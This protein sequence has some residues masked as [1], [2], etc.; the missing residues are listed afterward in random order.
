MGHHRFDQIDVD[1]SNLRVS[2]AGE[3]RPLE[4]RAFRLLQFLM[5]NRGRVVASDEIFAA[6]WGETFV[7]DN[8]LARLVAQIRKV[9]GDDPKEPRYI[10]TVPTVGYRF[11]PE[12]VSDEHVPIPAPVP[13]PV[14]PIVELVPKPAT[15]RRSR[16]A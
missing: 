1:V 15:G 6:V 5:Q 8:A 12:F 16:L 14:Q 4:P 3:I 7:T 11:V 10:E 9:L 2:V 13:G